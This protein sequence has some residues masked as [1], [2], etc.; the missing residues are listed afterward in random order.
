MARPKPTT[1]A[2]P[3]PTSVAKPK[4]TAVAKPR[5]PGAQS[6]QAR[7][8]KARLFNTQWNLNGKPAAYFPSEVSQCQLGS[9]D[10]VCVSDELEREEKFGVVSY[11]VNTS[12]S[13]FTSKS[14]FKVES[15][16]NVTLIFPNEPDNPDVI[17]PID[18]GIQEKQTMSC[19]IQGDSVTCIR[20]KSKT[21]VTF[22]QANS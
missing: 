2:K 17:I 19:T 5:K 18:Y 22:K 11:T 4:P 21:K 14:G 10:I 7:F 15:Q 8:A 6:R 12:I 9:N 13:D 20:D 16:E 1:V 3:K